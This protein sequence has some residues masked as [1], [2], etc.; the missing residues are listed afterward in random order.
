[1][2]PWKDL[3]TGFARRRG[4]GETLVPIPIAYCATVSS[5]RLTFFIRIKTA[6]KSVVR[7]YEPRQRQWAF[8]RQQQLDFAPLQAARYTRDD[9]V[10]G[11]WLAS[12]SR[13]WGCWRLAYGPWLGHATHRAMGQ[14]RYL[15]QSVKSTWNI[16]LLPAIMVRCIAPNTPKALKGALKYS[17]QNRRAI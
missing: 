15:R 1:M 3:L 4:V 11:D 5:T 8:M 13:L 9:T 2:Y 10:S 16:A 14:G 17:G 7:I 6:G 12:S